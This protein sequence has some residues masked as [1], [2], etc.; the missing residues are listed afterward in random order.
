MVSKNFNRKVHFIEVRDNYHESYLVFE[1]RLFVMKFCFKNLQTTNRK[2]HNL[3]FGYIKK[4]QS[5][6][7]S[8]FQSAAAAATRGGVDCFV[9]Y[10][11]RSSEGKQTSF[12][13]G[14]L[15]FFLL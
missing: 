3:S 6:N 13:A 12:I 2:N 10:V 14:R 9:K 5:V 8:L 15:Y 7:Q 4:K 1:Q 11:P